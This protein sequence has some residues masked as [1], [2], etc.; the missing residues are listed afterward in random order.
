MKFSCSREASETLLDLANCLETLSCKAGEVVFA[1]GDTAANLYL[2]RRGELRI[3]GCVGGSSRLCH[4]ATFGPGEFFG[5][6][7]FLDHRPRGNTAIASTDTELYVLTEEKFKY[8]AEEHKRIAFVL[9]CQLARTLAIR[10]RHT[11]DELMLLQES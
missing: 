9:I 6:L 10:L 11:D 3:M 1:R 4:I 8:L 5:G 2:I 7:A